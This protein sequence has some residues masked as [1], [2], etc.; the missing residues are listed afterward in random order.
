MI[1]VLAVV[2]GL[3]LVGVVRSAEGP[4]DGVVK[5]AAPIAHLPRPCQNEGPQL[6]IRH[7]AIRVTQLY[8]IDVHRIDGSPVSLSAYR[9]KVL[10]IVNVASK[11]GLTPQYDALEKVYETYSARGFEVLGFPAN[12]FLGQEPGSNQDIQEFCRLNF[13]VKFPMFEKIAV[14]GEGRH[15]LYNWLTDAEPNVGAGGLKHSLLKLIG[16]S[17]KKGEITWNFEKFVVSRAGE[18]VARFSPTRAPDAPVVI[19]AIER[20]LAEPA[21]GA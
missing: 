20:A 8:D 7:E 6:G 21:A 16:G 12:D 17:W 2:L 13:G 11:C 10:L 9:G 15:P 4:G 5:G 1:G 14:K 18:V 19:H 3:S